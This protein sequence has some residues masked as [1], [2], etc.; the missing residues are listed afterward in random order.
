MISRILK[1]I[2][3]KIETDLNNCLQQ[4]SVRVAG[5]AQH[6]SKNSELTPRGSKIANIRSVDVTGDHMSTLWR[7]IQFEELLSKEILQ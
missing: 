6:V 4:L 5:T 1:I 2:L 3:K 7:M